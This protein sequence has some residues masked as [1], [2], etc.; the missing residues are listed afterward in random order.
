MTDS[1]KAAANRKARDERKE[2]HL[3]AIFDRN[4]QHFRAAG[5]H[6]APAVARE[7]HVAIDRLVERDRKKDASS[8][9]IK[10]RKGC[11]HCCREPVEIWPHEAALLV[12]AAREAG[13]EL[14]KARLERQGHYTIDTWRQQPAADTACVFL[15]EDRAC[16]AYEFRPNACRKLLVVTDPERCDAGKH[17]PEE[18]GRWFSWEAEILESAALEVFGAGLMPQLLLSE[19][20]NKT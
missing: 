1:L 11:V 10:C 14:D 17:P 4:A 16:R 2:A 3:R 9:D 19:L 5:N 15:G 18:V 13:L 20:N 8:A 12:D 7:A 6:D